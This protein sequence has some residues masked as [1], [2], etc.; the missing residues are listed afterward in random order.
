MW[1]CV[2]AKL[3]SRH[4]FAVSLEKGSRVWKRDGGIIHPSLPL[5][6]LRGD[7][8][9]IDWTLQR[10]FILHGLLALLP[11]VCLYCC[12]T[13]GRP[14]WGLM[15][16]AKAW[17]WCPTS[18]EVQLNLDFCMNVVIGKATKTDHWKHLKMVK[19]KIYIYQIDIYWC[20]FSICYTF[21]I[22]HVKLKSA[23]GKR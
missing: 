20:I 17:H 2:G 10:G 22:I 21:S 1:M 18:Q 3:Y 13:L 15:P 7:D 11:N 12:L 14:S 8:L 23:G 19:S 9:L 4:F 16:L 6:G 5:P